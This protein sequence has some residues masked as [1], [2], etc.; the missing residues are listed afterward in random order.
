MTEFALWG[1]PL[2]HSFSQNYFRKKFRQQG[3]AAD[4]LLAEYDNLPEFQAWLSQHPLLR[5]FNITIPFKETAIALCDSLTETAQSIGAINC[6]KINPDGTKIGH[7]TDAEAFAIALQSFLGDYLPPMAL[8][9]GAGGSAKSVR[10]A[11]Q[12]LGISNMSVSRN[13]EKGDYTYDFLTPDLLTQFPLIVNTTPVGMF[14]QVTDMPLIPI[15]GISQQHYVFDLIYNP[16]ETALLN[17]SKKAGAAV[18]NGLSMLH[19]QAEASWRF[20]N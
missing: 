12:R 14:P 4:Y 7:N 15:D 6:I 20:W 8:V 10:Y 1:F 9:L 5:G 2:S 19:L 18:C 16:E 11:L 17:V 3:I 13:P